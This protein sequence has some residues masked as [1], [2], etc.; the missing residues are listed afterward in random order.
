MKYILNTVKVLAFLLVFSATAQQ[1]PNYALYKY[2][3]NII[4]PAYA[5]SNGFSQLSL[6]MR[7]QWVGVQDAPETQ[8]INYNGMLTEKVGF[9]MNVQRDNVFITNEY[10]VYADFSYKLDVADGMELFL[11]LKAGGTFLDIEFEKLGNATDPLLNT[12]VSEFNPNFG[13]GAYLKGEKFFVTLSTPKILQTDRYD[14]DGA[15]S[16]ASDEMHIYAGGGYTFDVSDNVMITPSVMGRY[17][18]GSPFSVDISATARFMDRFEVGANYRLDDSVAG[19][20]Y[21][22]IADWVGL[23]YAYERNISDV[24]DFNDGSHG[25]MVRFNMNGGGDDEEMMEESTDE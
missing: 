24:S 22:D 8:T 13:A 18:G 15:N 1:A 9:G 14:E 2:N 16:T 4:N 5:G 23:G 17:V 20:A 25:I 3:L 19:I 10:N 12:N 21:F 6:N 11:G 7:S